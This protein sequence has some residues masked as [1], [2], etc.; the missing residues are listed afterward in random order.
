MSKRS[1]SK[2]GHHHGYIK[3]AGKLARRIAILPGVKVIIPLKIISVARPNAVRLQ[4]SLPGALRVFVASTE[5]CQEL[6]VMLEPEA[7]RDTLEHAIA[8][9]LE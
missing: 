4:R 3:L 7:V 1:N 6:L 2:I 9:L 8:S 5:G